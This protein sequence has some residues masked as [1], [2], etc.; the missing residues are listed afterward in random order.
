MSLIVSW[1]DVECK[2]I[3]SGGGTIY[4]YKEHPLTG[5]IREVVNDV[6]VSECEYTDGH[7]GGIQRLYYSNG[8]IQE[9]FT[10]WFNKLEGTFT[11]WDENGNITGQTEWKN[12]VQISRK[13]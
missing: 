9:E 5:M 3:D 4:H 12:G 10:I 11:M 2:G 7:V 13:I 1:D 6:I 8:Q